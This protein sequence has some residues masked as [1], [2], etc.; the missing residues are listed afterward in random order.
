[1]RLWTLLRKDAKVIARSRLL[2]VTLVIYPLIIVAI[3]GYAFS[4]PT[5]RIPIAILNKDRNQNGDPNVG[6][7]QNPLDA[8]QQGILVSTTQLIEGVPAEGVPGLREFAELVFVDDED[9]GRRLLLRGEVQAL[10]VFPE[11]F[12]EALIGF[13]ES[14]SVRIIVDQSD[15][16]RANVTEILVRGVMQELQEQY[17]SQKVSFVVDAIDQSIN[18][19]PGQRLYP[20][21]NR[22][23][24]WVRAIIANNSAELD[25]NE[26]DQLEKLATFLTEVDEVLSDSRGIVDSVAKPVQAR[27]EG[28]KS[29]HL[30]VRDL[31]VPAA[32]GLSIF[33]TGSLATS[34][35]IV[36]EREAYAYRRLNITPTGRWSI[37]G[38][39]VFL[40]SF[41]ILLQ[42][43]FILVA[44]AIAWDTRIDNFPLTVLLVMTSTFASIGLGI[45][46]GG[47][48]KDVNG[49]V[50]LAV[51]TT[52]PMLFVSGL[53]YPVS[54]MPEG[55]QFLARLF[56]LTYTVEGLR[57][58]MLRGFDLADGAPMLLALAIFGIVLTVL[59]TWLGRLAE[60][61]TG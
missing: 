49:T 43:I 6:Y 7:I 44:A 54:F 53:F 26:K 57:G 42:S 32:L 14:A 59:G 36:Y 22:G 61:R 13:S 27:T 4:E 47:I 51:L 11:G 19:A 40:T 25:Q 48:S 9:E 30:F 1:M 15:V 55:A 3:I 34:S 5:D 50:L 37:V 18:P 45:F 16:V 20:G 46:L 10:V 38:A 56:P 39:K 23:A 12:V 52:F 41:I 35:L 2:L 17:V 58:S 21:F 8:T 24:N 28:E 31:I 60:R 33:W 29:G